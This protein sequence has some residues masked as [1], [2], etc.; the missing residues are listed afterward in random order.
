[1][2]FKLRAH[3]LGTACTSVLAMVAVPAI[4]QTVDVTKGNYLVGINQTVNGFQNNSVRLQSVNGGTDV[5]SQRTMLGTNVIGTVVNSTTGVATNTVTASLVGNLS[6][7]TLQSV[8]TND[9]IGTAP[10][11]ATTSSPIVPTAGGR[12]RATAVSSNANLAINTAQNVNDTNNAVGD[13]GADVINSSAIA[14][15]SNDVVTSTVKVDRNAQ[16][17]SGILNQNASV[18]DSTANATNATTAVATSQNITS[19]SIEVSNTSFAGITAAGVESVADTGNADRS[20]LALTNNT[21]SAVA[22]GNVS[23]N[24]IAVD[25]TDIT[26]IAVGPVS[27]TIATGQTQSAVATAGNAISSR[28]V[29]DLLT[30]DAGPISATLDGTSVGFAVS[31]ANDVTN[32]LVTNNTNTASAL[33]VGNEVANL[34][35]LDGNSI[36][37]K[38]AGTTEPVVAPVAAPGAAAAI[39]SQQN[40]AANLT[41]TAMAAAGQAVRTLVGADVED[42]TVTTSSNTVQATAIGNTGA[43]TVMADATTINTSASG[44]GTGATANAIGGMAGVVSTTGAGFEVSSAQSAAGSVT[45]TLRRD[46]ETDTAASIATVIGDNVR[47][48]TVQSN[49]NT[50]Q[51]SATANE[52]T[53][54][55]NKIVVSGTNIDTT[56]ALA[57]FQT[58]TAN[59]TAR[60]GAP[61]VPGSIKQVVLE[62]AIPETTQTFESVTI[63]ANSTKRVDVSGFSDAVNT[64]FA[65]QLNA[66]APPSVTIT[67]DSVNKELVFT[68]TNEFGAISPQ[69]TVTVPAI[70]AVTGPEFVPGTPGAGGVIISVGDDIT[71]STV[72]VDGNI[73]RGTVTGNIASNVIDVAATANLNDGSTLTTST[74]A[75]DGATPSSPIGVAKAEHALAN[76]QVVMG[77]DS[78]PAVFTADVAGTFAIIGDMNDYDTTD[79]TLSVSGNQMFATSR[80]NVVDNSI[81]L[82][83]TN[84][85]TGAAISSQQLG[86]M[87]GVTAPTSAVTVSATGVMDVFAPAAMSGSTLSLDRNRN[88]VVATVNTA[89]N[90]LAVDAVNIASI[91]NGA[92][93]DLLSSLTTS[94]LVNTAKGDFVIANGQTA[95][96]V[97][98]ATATS[99]VGNQDVDTVTPGDPPTDVPFPTAG[100][101]NSTATADANVTLAQASANRSTNT[102]ELGDDGGGDFK[103]TGAVLN[104]QASQTTVSATVTAVAE[105]DLRGTDQTGTDPDLSAISGSM[106]SVSNNAASAQARGNVSNNVLN[107]DA[108]SLTASATGGASGNLDSGNVADTGVK[109]S[110]GVLNHQYNAG[111]INATVTSARY[112]TTFDSAGTEPAV[113]N[114]SVSVLGNFVQASGIANSATNTMTLSALTHGSST[115]AIGSEQVNIANVTAMVSSAS[116]GTMSGGV[117]GSSVSVRGNTISSSA[118][119]NSAVNTLFRGKN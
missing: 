62:P 37:T 95:A 12:T 64:Q 87:P 97:A 104:V 61:A 27:T 5:Q 45:A 102:L 110:Y 118:I 107:V 114:S 88:E 1:M 51:A 98:S 48:S 78:V 15:V 56:T 39:A 73:T 18:I 16:N 115:G 76:T 14:S 106:A 19:S 54:Q 89:T 82:S 26:V 94:A 20:T 109:A 65:S 57:N 2:S 50:L 29:V 90:T 116:I 40:F 108:L 42:S 119:G 60:V 52:I 46:S 74:G 13:T 35:E 81:A 10:S 63:D 7:T 43:N 17:A 49:L 69:W 24:E 72:T 99:R 117:L 38:T 55:T 75:D 6:S 85:D 96:G 32:A 22:A 77:A 111:P 79:S 25:A 70:P 58:T 80:A 83:A 23:E 28:Q 59:V 100:I 101:L 41:A 112:G 93:V 66:E 4:A 47:D 92:N 86:G 71:R 9:M 113:L 68:N 103:A 91:S 36:V 3:L 44:T 21:Q 11:L 33:G 30:Q 8:V 34:V 105:L 67:Y 53:A 84:M 31:V